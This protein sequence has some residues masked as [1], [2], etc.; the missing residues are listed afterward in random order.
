[1]IGSNGCT[2]GCDPKNSVLT[3]SRTP[4]RAR[5]AEQLEGYFGRTSGAFRLCG[6][7]GPTLPDI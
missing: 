1:M 2:P 4:V 5:I 6:R 7:T 3:L